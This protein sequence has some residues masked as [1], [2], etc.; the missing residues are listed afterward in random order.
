MTIYAALLVPLLART[1]KSKLTPEEKTSLSCISMIFF[2]VGQILGS[3]VNGKCQDYLGTRIFTVVNIVEV[4]V[5]YALI[6]WFNYR[7]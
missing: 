5:A 2:G 7:D 1:M 4:V 3:F 6:M